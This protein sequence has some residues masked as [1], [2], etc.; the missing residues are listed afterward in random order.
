MPNIELSYE[1]I[2]GLVLDCK[3]PYS[4]GE[5]LCKFVGDKEFAEAYGK[6]ITSAHII[7][8]KTL[9]EAILEFALYMDEFKNSLQTITDITK[10]NS[11]EF[12][13][14]VVNTLISRG[15]IRVTPQ[16]L[17]EAVK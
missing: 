17:I 5:R 9:Q 1:E 2:M 14:M 13:A 11:K 16:L 12:G 8:N 7:E 3:V 15:L 6:S 10:V 4:V